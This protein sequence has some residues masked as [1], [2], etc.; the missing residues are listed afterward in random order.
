MLT[1]DNVDAAYYVLISEIIAFGRI[2]DPPKS[3]WSIGRNRHTLEAECSLICIT[4]PKD[5]MISSKKRQIRLPYILGN[6]MWTIFSSNKADMITY[7]NPKGKAYTEDKKTMG[8]A[9]GPRIVP[10]LKQCLDLFKEDINTRRSVVHFHSPSD[11]ARES[12]DIPCPISV[13]FLVREGKL[14]MIVS[15][16]SQSIVMVWPYDVALM[17]M[18]QE[19]IACQL[20]IPIGF[21]YHFS[22][23]A[24]IYEDKV[25]FGKVIMEE[26]D[27]DKE[28]K[29]VMMPP[30]DA[31]CFKDIELRK[32]KS[33]EQMKRTVGSIPTDI[34]F[35]SPFW[36][37]VAE[38]LKW[39]KNE[40]PQTILE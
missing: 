1:T 22:G 29:R 13:Q 16:R 27:L 33:Y 12:R 9:Y 14:D 31:N 15:M 19:M 28:S 3:K 25:G 40:I 6:F 4:N 2:V 26:M 24:H 30:M 20:G 37:W 32:V 21:Y 17:T 38:E 10:Q 35:K 34:K 11:L 18:I 7:Y 39:Y 8:G 23:S 36:G 5:R